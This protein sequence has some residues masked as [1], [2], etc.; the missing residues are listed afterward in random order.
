V[1]A[2]FIFAGATVGAAIPPAFRAEWQSAR[3]QCS[4][5][6]ENTLKI[7]RGRLHFYEATFEP[8]RARRI[9]SRTLSL[10]G[11]WHENGEATSVRL[12]LSLSSDNKHLTI[13]SP[14]WT[15][16]LQRC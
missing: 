15:N 5:D 3:T 6:Q 2:A 16:R 8:R 1:I 7:S 9:D 12:R 10:N 14:W 13:R 11:A 4:E